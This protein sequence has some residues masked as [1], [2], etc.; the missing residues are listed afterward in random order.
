MKRLQGQGQG[1]QQYPGNQQLLQAGPQPMVQPGAQQLNSMVGGPELGH[2]PSP[3]PGMLEARN[4]YRDSMQ[5]AVQG[6]VQPG[7]QGLWEGMQ[8]P[9]N[10]NPRLVQPQPNMRPFA[11]P[12]RDP[13]FGMGG[14]TGGGFPPPSRPSYG[15]IPSYQP[16]P[17]PPGTAPGMWGRPNMPGMLP[18]GVTKPMYPGGPGMLPPDVRGPGFG[19]LNMGR[20]PGMLPGREP[21]FGT[22]GM[23]PRPY[24]GG[25]VNYRDLGRPDPGFGPEGPGTMPIRNPYAPPGFNPWSGGEGMATAD[26]GLNEYLRRKQGGNPNWWEQGGGG[27]PGPQWGTGY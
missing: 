2:G 1:G 19:G 18:P 16:P 15:N 6:M 23:G 22:G 17:T 10:N 4:A 12:G 26:Q 27:A 9:P 5:K 24:P 13:N 25:P 3:Y 21:G 11:P 14:M 7:G 20:P 8:P